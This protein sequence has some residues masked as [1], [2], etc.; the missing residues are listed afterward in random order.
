[1]RYISFKLQLEP[2]VGR[3]DSTNHKPSCPRLQHRRG[4]EVFLQLL[5]QKPHKTPSTGAWGMSCSQV[6]GLLAACQ[7]DSSLRG[8]RRCCLQCSL[9]SVAEHHPLLLQLPTGT[10][11][12]TQHRHTA[13]GIWHLLRESTI[14]WFASS[15]FLAVPSR[16]RCLCQDASHSLK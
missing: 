8:W 6:L 7:T 13:D 5:H 2:R 11:T 4:W 16:G 3:E 14:G 9:P 15:W 12:A 1:M 10:G